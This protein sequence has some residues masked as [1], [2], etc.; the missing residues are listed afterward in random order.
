MVRMKTVLW[1]EEYSS[2]VLERLIRRRV[3]SKRVPARIPIYIMNSCN[4]EVKHQECSKR[5]ACEGNCDQIKSKQ[6]IVEVN[7]D[8]IVGCCCL[9]NEQ[10]PNAGVD[11]SSRNKI[12]HQ[13]TRFVILSRRARDRPETS[14]GNETCSHGSLVPGLSLF[15]QYWVMKSDLDIGLVATSTSSGC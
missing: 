11:F 6:M 1:Q 3:R 12:L 7:L 2:E 14:N 13:G 5:Q 9:I 10:F 15:R 8:K 4:V